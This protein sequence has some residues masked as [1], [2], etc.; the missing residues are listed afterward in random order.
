[1]MYFKMNTEDN[2]E[3]RDIQVALLDDEYYSFPHVSEAWDQA[4]CKD[5]LSAAKSTK[6][7]MWKD[8]SSAAG[9]EWRTPLIEKI[10]P[11]WWYI[12]VVSCRGASVS[13]NYDIH[14][15]NQLQ[16]SNK[17]YSMDMVGVASMSQFFFLVF[18]I[19]AAIHYVSMQ[20]W[21]T[22]TIGPG[23]GSWVLSGHP[24]LR[25]LTLSTWCAALGSVAWMKYYWTYSSD[26]EGIE[27]CALVGRAN[28]IASKVAIS[29][30]VL[31]LAK[32]E[33]VCH[34]YTDW[35]DH[36]LMM[37]GLVAFGVLCFFLE[38]WGESEARSSVTAYA[39]DTTGGTMLVAF[40]FVFLLYY[41]SELRKTLARETR[42]KQRSF[43]TTYGAALGGWFAVLPGVA[44]L[45]YFLAAHVRYRIVFSVCNLT[46]VSALAFL[47][48]TFEPSKAPAYYEISSGSSESADEL[49][50]ILSRDDCL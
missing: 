3:S 7:L 20:S 15:V 43:F 21:T 1:M 32:G 11:R 8:L 9:T 19:L 22:T 48:Y 2:G 28:M 35:A 42:L 38:L 14:L 23:N 4:P 34:H 46:H 36:E 18:I 37:K 41:I 33:V 10:R 29:V 45:A 26:G 30:L 39:Y 13:I 25:M 6:Q 5:I 16:G 24:V 40:D 44:V 31:L 12:A 49:K 17:E 47:V 50:G 27:W